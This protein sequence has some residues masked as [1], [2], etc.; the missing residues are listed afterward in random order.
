M[1]RRLKIAARQ[2]GVG[3]ASYCIHTYYYISLAIYIPVRPG[4]RAGRVVIEY[5]LELILS[6]LRDSYSSCIGKVE[7]RFMMYMFMVR[8]K[9]LYINK[10]NMFTYIRGCIYA[11]MYVYIFFNE[12]YNIL[13]F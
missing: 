6:Y 7:I 13:Q 4:D 3:V 9:H 12:V 10:L 1:G 11:G 8:C 5:I 2:S